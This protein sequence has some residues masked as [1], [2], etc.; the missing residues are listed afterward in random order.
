M[1]KSLGKSHNDQNYII[2]DPSYHITLIH[3]Q[4]SS[5]CT[6]FGFQIV[7]Q[8]DK[9]TCHLWPW[10][11]SFPI[12]NVKLSLGVFALKKG[13]KEQKHL[14]AVNLFSNDTSL[15]CYMKEDHSEIQENFTCLKRHKC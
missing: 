2:W 12:E 13:K 14:P 9:Q 10:F 15:A 7:K 4:S 1:H 6:C 3:N 5:K 8:W 11:A